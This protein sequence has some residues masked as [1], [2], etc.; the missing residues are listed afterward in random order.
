MKTYK[1]KEHDTL[2]KIS[3]KEGV[4]IEAIAAANKLKGRKIHQLSI[5][6]IL[7]IPEPQDRKGDTKLS[8]GFRGLDHGTVTPKR[9]KVEYDG[10]VEEH[11]VEGGNPITLFVQDH[12]R[13]LKVWVEN[14]QKELEQTFSAD[15]LPIGEW[16]LNIDSRKVKAEGAA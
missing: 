16:K 11:K 5:D 7:L 8:V 13:G 3:R 1:V 4:S 9:V 2:W 15:I 14:L 12:A 6:Q 10:R